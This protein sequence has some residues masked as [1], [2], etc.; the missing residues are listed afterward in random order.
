MPL[1]N[2][3]IPKMERRSKMT[4]TVCL[5]TRGR[6]S[7]LR[8][9]VERTLKNAILPTTKVV[10][11]VDLDDPDRPGELQRLLDDEQILW[12]YGAREDSLGAKYNRVAAHCPADIYLG[13]TDDAWIDAPGWDA[14]L[15][16]LCA[17]FP[18][19][20][21]CVYVGRM[22]IPSTLPA[23]QAVTQGLVDRMG[24]FMC[25]D[26]PFW[27]HD[28]WL[29]E[30][31]HYIGRVV[32]SGI[33]VGYPEQNPGSRGLRELDFWARHFDETRAGRRLMALDVINNPDFAET[34]MRR[35]QLR[36]QLP[37]LD[38]WFVHRN[39]FLRNPENARRL[40]REA[41]I[42]NGGAPDERYAR[43]KAAAERRMGVAR[44][45]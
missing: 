18:D 10:V 44:A 3:P 32:H 41:G 34:E 11:G 28:T 31:A 33:K 22:N 12:S 20:I 17:L 38:A 6:P 37:K 19:G 25:P 23:M 14:E 26:Y 2:L 21:G 45:A 24:H 36:S 9:A 8:Q 39:S 29:D 4:I 27:W 30:F 42:D 15:E 1:P 16:R 7:L 43:L 13:A 40:E 5:A 35:H